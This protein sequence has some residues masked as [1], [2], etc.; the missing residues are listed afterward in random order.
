MWVNPKRGMEMVY[1]APGDFILGTSDAQIDA[2][3]REHPADE[4]EFFEIEQPQCRVNLPGYWMGRTEVTN[5]QYERFVQATGRDAPD[6]WEGR[7]A[8]SG[9]GGFPV[10]CVCWDDASAYCAWAG[11]SLP[12]ELQW[13]KAARGT[14][15]RVFPWGSEWDRTRCRN[16]QVITGRAY[17]S[18]SEW[19]TACE[20]WM[21]AHDPVREGPT[22]VGSYPGGTSPYGCADMAGNVVELCAE[23]YDKTA[24]Q[25]YAKGDLT[26]PKT[27]DYIVVRGG[28]WG[29]G[30][31]EDFRCANRDHDLP[32]NRDNICYGFR[33]ARGSA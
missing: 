16:F 24:Y 18:L 25:R 17:A 23:W 13:E 27:G 12:T 2:W 8:P 30:D 11:E 7:K 20:N 21:Q 4:R 10:M 28:S 9:L 19:D 31:P 5:A 32:D 15:G 29:H 22:A 3:L 1:V 6:Y 33:C 26:P 14:D